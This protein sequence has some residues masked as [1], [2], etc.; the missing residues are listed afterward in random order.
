[1]SEKV[2]FLEVTPAA[3]F[4]PKI[5]NED[6]CIHDEDAML[7]SSGLGK[8]LLRDHVGTG[9]IAQNIR[10]RRAG[11]LLFHLVNQGLAFDR[12]R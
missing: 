9:P 1:M 7:L 3:P 8:R 6:V 5:L 10:L 2:T 4:E 12:V 11:V